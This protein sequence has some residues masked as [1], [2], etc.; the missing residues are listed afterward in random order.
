MYNGI[1]L[2]TAR[3]SGTSGHIQK[4]LSHYKPRDATTSRHAAELPTAGTK[5]DAGILDH[6][7][8]R[9]VEVR[10]MQLRDELEDQGV[11]EE[12]IEAQVDVLRQKLLRSSQ[13]SQPSRA[14][15]KALRPSDV[16]ARS[17][18]K[19]REM[20]AF[21]R[22]LRID[23]NYVEGQAWDKDL[24]ERR[25]VERI[26]TKRRKAEEAEER[27]RAWAEA[28]RESQRAEDSMRRRPANREGERTS[29]SPPSRVRRRSYS[30][31]VSS[32]S[33]SPTPRRSFSSTSRSPQ[34]QSLTR[35]DERPPPSRPSRRRSYTESRSRSPG[36]RSPTSASDSRSPS[37]APM[38]HSSR[39]KGTRSPPQRSRR[40]PTHE[41]ESE[42]IDDSDRS[43]SSSSVP[44]MTASRRP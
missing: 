32:R 37:P 26:E 22:A 13:W 34:R 28:Q 15:I 30:D 41:S 43:R 31:S 19:S 27:N 33:R 29:R 1:G 23:S 35:S 7:R 42:S 14:D 4:N 16:H 20:A 8:K 5:Q 24:Q 3:G 18:A 21:G 17:A 39:S 11:G 9:K 6:E 2:P 44:S 38:T 40:R 36:P 12:E 10:C 25:K